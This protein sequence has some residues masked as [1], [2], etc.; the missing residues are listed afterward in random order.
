[1]GYKDDLNWYAYVGNNPVNFTDPTGLI[2]SLSGGNF[3]T[4]TAAAPAT[5]PKL[6]GVAFTMP[7]SQMGDATQVAGVKNGDTMGGNIR[8]NSQT[9][10]VSVA[11]KLTPKQENTLHGWVTGQGLNYHEIMEEAKMLFNK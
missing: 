7:A 10:A 11:L 4:N 1:V 9:R 6:D 5:A 8:E 3:T 2:A